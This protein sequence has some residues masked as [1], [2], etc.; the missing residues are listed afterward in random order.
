MLSH[1]LFW[2][3]LLPVPHQ[4][5]QTELYCHVLVTRHEVWIGSRI[6]WTLTNCYWKW[7]YCCNSCTLL[8]NVA[9]SKSSLSLLAIARERILTMS[10]SADV[11]AGLRLL[12][13][14]T[15]PQLTHDCD[16]FLKSS[17]SQP[18]YRPHGKHRLQ[19]FFRCCALVVYRPLRSE[20][21]LFIDALIVP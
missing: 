4:K 15:W 12:T 20:G 5:T 19:Q 9:L 1:I 13:T 17:R 6:Y 11:V 18:W 2:M 8:F 7:L 3:F 16:C 10:T 21:S 14:N